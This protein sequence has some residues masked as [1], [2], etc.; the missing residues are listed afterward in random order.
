MNHYSLYPEP[1]HIS[2]GFYLDAAS[3][4]DAFT[5][6]YDQV[7]AAGAVPTGVLEIVRAPAFPHFAMISDLASQLESLELNVRKEHELDQWMRWLHA[8]DPAVHVLR[9]AFDAP[10]AGLAVVAFEP[11][12]EGSGA[13]ALHPVS[14]TMSG[15]LLSMP[16]HVSLNKRERAQALLVARFLMTVFRSV[17]ESHDP[18]Y[19]SIAVE[20]SLPT[21]IELAAGRARVGTELFFSARLETAD[22]TLER[23]LATIFAGGFSERWTKGIFFSGWAAFNTGG[24]L[25]DEPLAVS[26]RAAH[27]LGQALTMYSEL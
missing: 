14:V 18:L 6:V 4:R 20:A 24:N 8:Q 5:G 23:D 22:P 19:G 2:V 1:P 25:V 15:S 27:R 7:A 21:P 12:P 9:A 16:A 17:C 10:R 11:I 13:D 26:T 3:P